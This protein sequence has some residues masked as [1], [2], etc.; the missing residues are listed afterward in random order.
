[1]VLLFIRSK[2]MPGDIHFLFCNCNLVNRE[3]NPVKRLHSNVVAMFSRKYLFKL[4][5]KSVIYFVKFKME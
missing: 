1:M 4:Y 2:F 5:M 3:I